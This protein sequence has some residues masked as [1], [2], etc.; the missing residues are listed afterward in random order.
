ME[1]K[2][3]LIWKQVWN[4][5]AFWIQIYFQVPSHIEDLY[6]AVHLFEI[7][8]LTQNTEY[9]KETLTAMFCFHSNQL[10]SRYHLSTWAQIVWKQ[11]R[12]Q[13]SQYIEIPSKY[14]LKLEIFCWK[15]HFWTGS[16]DNQAIYPFQKGNSFRICIQLPTVW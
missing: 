8:A 1:Y 13:Y 12:V 5:E 4:N 15:V 7:E 16:H 6:F 11:L 9:W 2:S 3:S 10:E 14:L